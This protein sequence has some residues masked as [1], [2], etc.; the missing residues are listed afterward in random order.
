MNIVNTANDPAALFILIKSNAS[1]QIYPLKF[2]IGMLQTKVNIQN[3][4]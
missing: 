1:R 2:S 4:V 3:T